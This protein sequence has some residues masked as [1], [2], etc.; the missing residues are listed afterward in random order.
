MSDL[1]QVSLFSFFIGGMLTFFFFH[2]GLLE[3]RVVGGSPLTG[4]TRLRHDRGER[5]SK[6]FFFMMFSLFFVV[7]MNE[8]A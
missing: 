5:S 7:K 4:E 2:R 3:T 6:Q 1:Q 8:Q